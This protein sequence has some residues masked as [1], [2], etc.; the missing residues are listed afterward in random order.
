MGQW[1]ETNR[2]VVFPAQCDHLGHMN[3]RYYA[4]IFDDASFHCW[5]NI[6][7]NFEDMHAQG[8]VTVV[9]HTATD[10]IREVV[11]GSLVRVE[12]A[13]VKLGTKS[14]TYHQRLI[15][16]ETGVLHARQ[17]QVEAFINFESRKS[18]AIP[19]AFRDKITAA[20]VEDAE[21]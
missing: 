4:H 17:R 20:L 7:I 11:A 2:A 16:A 14:A 3:V 12:S 13:F 15:N 21:P 10:F 8:A 18:V 19:D 5:A 6:G 9:A 1:M